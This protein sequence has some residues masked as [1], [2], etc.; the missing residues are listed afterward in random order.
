VFGND[1][2]QDEIVKANFVSARLSCAIDGATI[3]RGLSEMQTFVSQALLARLIY[4]L[5]DMDYNFKLRLL[6]FPKIL[7][8]PLLVAPDFSTRVMAERIIYDLFPTMVPPRNS[9]MA[10]VLLESEQ[11]NFGDQGTVSDFQIDSLDADNFR[12]LM[13]EVGDFCGEVG[14]DLPDGQHRLS[15]LFRV[16]RWG[17]TRF[18]SIAQAVGGP[19]WSLFI[20]VGASEWRS[21]CNL[22]ESIRAIASLPCVMRDSLI[23]GNLATFSAA[24][25]P[26]D[27]EQETK[28]HATI[29]LDILFHFAAYLPLLKTETGFCETFRAFWDIPIGDEDQAWIVSRVDELGSSIQ[30]AASVSQLVGVFQ[31]DCLPLSILPILVRASLAGPPLLPVLRTVM[32][33]CDMLFAESGVVE[34]ILD[35][36]AAELFDGLRPLLK[37]SGD[38]VRVCRDSLQSLCAL[39]LSPNSFEYRQHVL[40][41]IE[42][43]ALLDAQIRNDVLATL[44]GEIPQ[45]DDVQVMWD[46]LALRLFC[47][48]LVDDNER[49]IGQCLEDAIMAATKGSSGSGFIGQI[50]GVLGEPQIKTHSAALRRLLLAFETQITAPGAMPT[51]VAATTSM[52]DDF[53]ECLMV[54]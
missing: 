7:V 26:I 6:L 1:D 5:L 15:S 29:F 41:F 30:I 9:E 47:V 34:L 49:M 12:H 38:A 51:K 53:R 42:E 21:G 11:Y 24:V 35:L 48:S 45:I 31:C 25:F 33:L 44:L 17:L 37:G 10:E 32:V 28:L 27:F 14:S 4:R 20:A 54:A 39:F 36:C 52:L 2:E 40:E 43:L 50:R 18:E 22:Y 3:T 19:L 8:C 13:S 23:R 16:I 46:A